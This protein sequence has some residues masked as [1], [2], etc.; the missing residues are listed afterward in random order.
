MKPSASKQPTMPTL[1][2]ILALGLQPGDRARDRDTECAIC[3]NR[4]RA[5][6]VTECLHVFCYEC[7]AMWMQRRMSC[8]TCRTDLRAPRA[9]Q[10]EAMNGRRQEVDQSAGA[11][12]SLRPGRHHRRQL[13]PTYMLARVLRSDTVPTTLRTTDARPITRTNSDSTAPTSQYGG[14]ALAR[15]TSRSAPTPSHRSTTS[16]TSSALRTTSTRDDRSSN[17][18]ESN[19]RHR[20]TGSRDSSR[21]ARSVS[22]ERANLE[23]RRYNHNSTPTTDSARATASRRARVVTVDAVRKTQAMQRAACDLGMSREIRNDARHADAADYVVQRWGGALEALDGR[24]YL[25]EDLLGRLKEHMDCELVEQ[26]FVRRARAVS[27]GFRRFLELI[28]RAAVEAR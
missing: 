9:R 26:G 14:E 24:R 3:F 27:S 11:L 21:H 13:E 8:P 19:S 28:A 18:T 25:E 10:V 16:S 20:L 17:S 4:V 6:V 23:I 5:S 22:E 2:H 12:Q 7:L 1:P 15:Q